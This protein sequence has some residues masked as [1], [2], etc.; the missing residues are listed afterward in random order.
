MHQFKVS[1]LNSVH[2][3][4]DSYPYY[5]FF[6]QFFHD[7]NFDPYSSSWKF[8]IFFCFTS[9]VT[10]FMSIYM[11]NALLQAKFISGAVEQIKEWVAQLW[12]WNMCKH[13][14]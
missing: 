9:F 2:L 4:C 11:D 8:S 7:H 1:G 3:I 12:V 13:D 5:F 10:F 14:W 6:A